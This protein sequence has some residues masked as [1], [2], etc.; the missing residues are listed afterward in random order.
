MKT[1]GTVTVKNKTYPYSI[2]RVDSNVIFFVAKDAKINQEFLTEDIAGLII[3][4]PSLI[5][6][7]QKHVQ[8]QSD[9]IRFRVSG[10][11]KSKIEKK[12]LEKGY[13]SV[14][15]YLRDLALG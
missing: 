3:D 8:K 5:L 11:D 7:E 15:G 4:L 12:A 10:S 9:V 6:A 1:T 2:E 13:D 14:S